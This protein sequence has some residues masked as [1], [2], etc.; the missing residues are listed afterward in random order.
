ML[1][2]ARNESRIQMKFKA[3]ELLDSLMALDLHCR[4]VGFLSKK[5]KHIGFDTRQGGEERV[6]PFLELTLYKEYAKFTW[7]KHLTKEE[8]KVV[9]PYADYVS[10]NEYAD[11][12]ANFIIKYFDSIKVVWI[13]KGV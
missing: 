12:L 1:V 10:V 9:F 8:K 11:Y 5:K 2:V 4:W 7:G 3:E 13:R 6:S